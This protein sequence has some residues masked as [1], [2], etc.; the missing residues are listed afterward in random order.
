[1]LWRGGAHSNAALLQHSSSRKTDIRVW[2]SH[3]VGQHRT[4]RGDEH[5]GAL[6][7]VVVADEAFHGQVDQH[8][9]HHPDGEN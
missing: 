7:A 5:D 6:D 2:L 4:S 1:M 8:P 9:C 3:D